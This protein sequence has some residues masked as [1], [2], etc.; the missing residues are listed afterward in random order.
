AL[1][2]FLRAR[3]IGIQ[4]AGRTLAALQYADDT[5]AFMPSAAQVPTLREAIHIFGNAT[6]Q[7]LNPSKTVLLPVGAAPADLPAEVEGLRVVSAATSLGVTFGAAAAPTTRWPEL[8][9]GVKACYS[10][11]ASI[12][13]L[14]VFGR[15]FAS[16]A[17]GISKLLYHAEFAGHPPDDVLQ[18][19]TRFT[20][21]VVDRG[22]APADSVRRFP[23]LASWVLP[24][25]PAEGGF[26]TLAWQEHIYSRHAKWGV[27]L[28][29]GSE[30][31]P[32]VAVARELLRRCLPEV[33]AHPLGLL[34]WPAGG[35]EHPPGAVAPLPPPPFSACTL[36]CSSCPLFRTLQRGP[37]RWATGAGQPRCGATPSS[38]PPCCPTASTT[39]SSTLRALASPPW[40]SCC[41]PSRRL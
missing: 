41:T 18:Q 5:E 21:K 38:A 35:T 12:P 26:G 32:W 28:A 19:L 4:V 25:R 11:I 39:A 9:D 37:S 23:G 33:G 1:L 7:R 36:A 6:G 10:R 15:G 13:K 3:G 27:Q 34:L 2:R 22:Q 8:L 24:G 29:L 40:A 31:V 14:S 30:D 20:A 17:Y 16:A